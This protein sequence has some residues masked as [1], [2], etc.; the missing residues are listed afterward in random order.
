MNKQEKIDKT[1]ELYGNPSVQVG[2]TN[3]V[4]SRQSREDVK[5][6]EEKTDKDLMD[7]AISINWV[8]HCLGQISLGELQRLDLILIELDSRLPQN[9]FK[10]FCERLSADIERRDEIQEEFYKAMEQ[11]NQ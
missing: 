8:N 7:E 11:R 6:L 10:K 5:E 4:F 1:L 3:I 9:K 2:D